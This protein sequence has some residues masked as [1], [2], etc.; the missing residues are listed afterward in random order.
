M[1]NSLAQFIINWPTR[2][3][4][5]NQPVTDYIAPLVLLPAQLA[6]NNL[7]VLFSPVIPAKVL[8]IMSILLLIAVTSKVREV[9]IVRICI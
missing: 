1:A 2:H 3:S 8:Y 5:A 7:G 4:Q 9:N 6:G